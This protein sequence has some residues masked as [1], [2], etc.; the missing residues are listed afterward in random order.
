MPFSPSTVVNLRE[1]DDTWE[2]QERSVY[3]NEVIYSPTNLMSRKGKDYTVQASIGIALLLIVLTVTSVTVRNSA[4]A[5][6]DTIAVASSP[7]PIPTP[8]PSVSSSSE[9]ESVTI[10]MIL[11]GTLIYSLMRKLEEI[12]ALDRAKTEECE[13]NENRSTAKSPTRQN[14]STKISLSIVLWR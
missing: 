10:Y 12:P 4:Q 13:R 11:I 5:K 9:I 1:T 6:K 2:F 7:T 14:L 8:I 3:Y